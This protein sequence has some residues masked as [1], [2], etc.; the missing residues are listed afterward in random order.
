MDDLPGFL[1]GMQGVRGS[2]PL[3]STP[4]QR[5]SPPPTAGQSRPSAQ[6]IRSTASARPMRSS[7][8]AVAR[9]SIAGLFPVDAPH[10]AAASAA[11]VVA[12]GS[13]GPSRV[14]V[15]TARTRLA[16]PSFHPGFKLFYRQDPSLMMTAQVMRCGHSRRSSPTSAYE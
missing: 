6:Q 3:S 10:R 8:A 5:P 14:A 16:I 11:V 1:D 4:G 13:T 12:A 9:P 15:R 7:S 2:N